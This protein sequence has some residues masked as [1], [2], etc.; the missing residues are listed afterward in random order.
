MGLSDLN[1]LQKVIEGTQKTRSG[2]HNI[3]ELIYTNKHE[4]ISNIYIQPSEITD[5]KYMCETLHIV[6]YN[7]KHVLKKE[8]N[9]F[10]YNYNTA[11]WKS[12]KSSLRNIKWVEILK[13]C[14][15]FEKKFN[16]ILEVVIKVEE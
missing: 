15:I 16:K 8:L 1:F 5:H 7:D 9:L 2:S 3:L 12:I 13:N 11:I 14:K 6:Q 4:P 10:T